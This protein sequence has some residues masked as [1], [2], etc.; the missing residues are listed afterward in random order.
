MLAIRAISNA[1]DH[2]MLSESGVSTMSII[3]NANAWL[4]RSFVPVLRVLSPCPAD[5]ATKSTLLMSIPLHVLSH[6]PMAVVEPLRHSG[7]RKCQLVPN[8]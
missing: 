7:Y 2:W 6:C 4:R 3:T 1:R 5:A 8:G